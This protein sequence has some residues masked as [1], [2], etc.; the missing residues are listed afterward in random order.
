MEPDRFGF[1]KPSVDAHVLG[2]TSAGNL[3]EDLG[4]EV[5]YAPPQV[6]R[7]CDR[8]E[9]ERESIELEDWIRQARISRLGFSYR[10]SPE[11]GVDLFAR[12]VR[13]L[14]RRSLFSDQGGPLK[15]LYFAGLPAACRQARERVPRVNAVFDG[16][17]TAQETLHRLGIRPGSVPAESARAIAYDSDRLAFGEELV[18]RGAYRS[19]GAPARGGYPEYGTAS[20]TVS[21]R[22]AQ[23]ARRGELPL[24]R[25]HMGKY[26]PDR[27]EAVRLFY[28]WA[29]D[30]ADLGQLDVLSVGSSQLSQERFGEDWGESP[31][32]GG[33]PLNSREELA[34]AWRAA[35]PMLVRS[36]AGTKN[37]AAMARM[38]DQALHNA[39]HALSVWW[40][41][42]LDGRG[43]YGLREN[44]GQMVEALRY[45]AAAGKPFEPNVP[46]HFA[47]RGADE[48]S[49]VVSGYLAAR[50]AKALGVQQLI[51]QNML[52]TPRYI[53][54]VQDLARSRT[55]LRLVRTLQDEKFSVVLQTRAGLDSLSA[56]PLR[57]RAQLAAVT[58]LMD[59]IEPHDAGSP[60]IIHV[61]SWSEATQFADPSIIT[62]SVRIC[63]Q[64]L[65]DYR[66]LRAKGSIDDMSASA[67]V[68]RRAEEL[69]AEAR[70]VI[71]A[72][73]RFVE[74]PSSADGL[75]TIFAAGFLPVPYLW[76]CRDELPGAVSW[77]TRL[78]AGAVR[79]VDEHGT[80]LSI[81][82]RIERARA[83][84]A[85]MRQ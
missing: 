25:A 16:E 23:A 61:V 37:L 69:E 7:A 2:L 49:Y 8:P 17:E 55:L 40:F 53:W 27:Q 41:C 45:I 22:I 39:W 42:R 13:Q 4:K 80:P 1:L 19:L 70:A 67:E 66:L 59:D 34:E 3:L 68:A 12:L 52:N 81:E 63:R 57:A 31:N 11:D 29:R 38:N 71:A 6:C 74:G 26:L 77:K 35:R 75:F 44:L 5:I 60:Q 56:D 83:H 78:S 20:E 50:T 84:L 46:H 54:G 76:E 36:Y 24:Y 10:L 28:R 72:I 65:A 43:P 18:R 58:A 9:G 21:A 33:V 32:G 48:A 14:E 62:E 30:L 85:A 51:V 79:L 73:D 15:A 82:R 47:F 64:A